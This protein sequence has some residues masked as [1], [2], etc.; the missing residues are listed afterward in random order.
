MQ[1]RNQFK[2][3]CQRCEQHSHSRSPRLVGRRPQSPLL[4]S[5]LA[6]STRFAL[7]GLARLVKALVVCTVL[8]VSAQ[9]T[10]QQYLKSLRLGS[11]DRSQWQSLLQQ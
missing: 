3:L 10:T 2:S 6:S 9:H 4:A 7:L 8:P 11:L 1:E 5:S